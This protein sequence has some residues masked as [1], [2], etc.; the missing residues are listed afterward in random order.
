MPTVP[1]TCVAVAGPA[2]GQAGRDQPLLAAMLRSLA[3]ALMVGAVGCALMGVATLGQ[4]SLPGAPTGV[5][6]PAGPTVTMTLVGP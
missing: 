5:P 2:P 6:G 4:G 3:R 1:S